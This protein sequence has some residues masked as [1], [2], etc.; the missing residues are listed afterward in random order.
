MTPVNGSETAPLKLLPLVELPA[1]NIPGTP[2]P[3]AL[4]GADRDTDALAASVKV[5]EDMI[6]TPVP[7]IVAAPLNV[8]FPFTI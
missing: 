1:N 8:T 6:V 2:F 5:P 7:V 4:V 3:E